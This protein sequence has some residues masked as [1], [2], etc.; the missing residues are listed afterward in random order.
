MHGGQFSKVGLLQEHI[1]TLGLAD[2]GPPVGSHIYNHSLGDFP[3]RPVQVFEVLRDFGDVL[4]RPVGGNQSVF[5]VV[6]PQP[7]VDQILH[8]VLIDHDKFA[9]KGSSGIDI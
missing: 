1:H 8:E 4:N 5:H 2:I 7:Q 9:G 6:I 3:N